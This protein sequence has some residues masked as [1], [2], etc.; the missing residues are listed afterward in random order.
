MGDIYDS[1]FR[2]VLNDCRKLIIP[3]LNVA[4]GENYTGDEKVEFYPN[5]HF[6]KQ[7]DEMDIK[8]ITDTNFAVYGIGGIKKKYHWECQST[9]DSKIVIRLFEYDAQIA[10]DEGDVSGERLTVEFP[11][12]AVL[13][14]RG[15]KNVDNYRFT[16]KTPGGTVEYDVPLIKMQQYSLDEIFE[17]KL[18]ML[19]P[20][21]IFTKESEFQ[22]CEENADKLEKLKGEYQ[23]IVNRLEQLLED[24][25]MT[26]F[27]KISL[28]EATENVIKEIAKKY[29]KVR[30]GV[31]EAMRGPLLESNARKF[32][33]E[34]IELG[35]SIVVLNMYKK[36]YTVEQISDM[37]ELDIESV[38]AIVEGK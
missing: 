2:T 33:D 9:P 7:Q 37:I 25:E 23:D 13:Y 20:F 36:G 38:K 8:R 26:Y 22:E 24:G 32:R 27:D 17:K 10:L 35:I 4:F 12:T 21:Y 1:A 3:L 15:G 34:G 14:L 18:Y 16:I 6:I 31:N 11:H 30:E 19:I 29:E 5:E 28:L